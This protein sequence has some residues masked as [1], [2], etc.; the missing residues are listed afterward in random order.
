MYTEPVLTVQTL[1]SPGKVYTKPVLTVQ[2]YKT[3]FDDSINIHQ[4]RFNSTCGHKTRYYSTNVDKTSLNSRTIQ[5]S[6]F[7]ITNVH[8]SIS[9]LFQNIYLSSSQDLSQCLFF[10][11]GF[12]EENTKK[13]RKMVFFFFFKQ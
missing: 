7:D 5:K 2:I 9:N 6:C 12:C 4:T 11:E 8:K 3:G 10:N 13:K 1:S